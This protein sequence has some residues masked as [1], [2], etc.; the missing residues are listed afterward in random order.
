VSAATR[1]TTPDLEL[2][3]RLRD[4]L[5]EPATEAELRTSIEQADAL[6]RVTR[7]QMEGS[8]RRLDELTSDPASALAE[9]AAELHRVD[10]L[11]RD[12]REAGRLQ[13]ALEERAQELRSRWLLRQA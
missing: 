3:R 1:A 5:D 7:G 4:V 8:E 9:V 13:A 6:V 12:L 11:G 2:L 10:A